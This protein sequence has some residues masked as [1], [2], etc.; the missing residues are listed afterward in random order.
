MPAFYCGLDHSTKELTA[1]DKRNL[2]EWYE[3]TI[4]WGAARSLVPGQARSALA[5]SHPRALGKLLPGACRSR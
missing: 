5:E 1:Q 3:R 4:G 2:E